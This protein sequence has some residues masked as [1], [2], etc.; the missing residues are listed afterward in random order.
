MNNDKLLV[1]GASGHLG[2]RVLELLLAKKAGPIVATTRTP[3][4]LKDFAARGVEVRTA[5]FDEPASLAAAF[6]G[7][8][9]AL[10]ISTDALDRPGRRVEQHKNAIAAL[11]AAGA[12]HVAYTSLANAYRG[13]P[14][15]LAEDHLQ[16]E[17]RIQSGKLGYSILRNNYYADLVPLALAGAVKTGQLVDA[18]ADG[19]LAYVTR[20]D[21]AQ[22]AAAALTDGFDG[23]RVLEV[24]GPEAISS[25]Q[26]AQ[27][28]SELSGKK[29]THLSVPLE[30]LIQGM[31]AHGLPEP[32]ARIYAGFDV[33]TAKGD[34]ATVTDSVEKLTKR[35]PQT[36]KS[37]LAA[38]KAAWAG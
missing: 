31:V 6:K 20:E 25:A 28:A 26:L 5:S 29:I 17:A 23:K 32:V 33:A 11:E 30:A 10:L 15:S 19:K 13:S 9:R 7:T 3:E 38:N 16:T 8:S 21:C 14:I 2:R 36:L 34:L 22:I 1:T 4:A 18:K 37:F 27:I 12:S 24:S 35:Q